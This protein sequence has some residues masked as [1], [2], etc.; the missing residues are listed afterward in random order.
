MAAIEHTIHLMLEPVS[1][2]TAVGQR[3][4]VARQQQRRTHDRFAEFRQQQARHFVVGHADADGAPLVVLQAPRRFL[5]G[6]QQEGVR[7]RRRRLEHAE[8]PGF[9]LGV[10]GDLGE[11]AAH[12]REMV[13]AIGLADAPDAIE[14]VLVADVAAERVAG[15]R[16]VHD[17]RRRRAR[18]RRRAGSGAAADCRDEARNTGS[19]VGTLR[20]Q[21]TAPRGAVIIRARV[22]PR[23]RRL[24]VTMQTLLEYAPWI[25]FGL[26]YKFG[27]GI[28]PGDRRAHGR[29]DAAAR[30]IT[31]SAHAR[32]RR[33]TSVLTVLVWVF[34]AATLILHDVRFLQWKASVIYWLDRH[35][36]SPA[37]SG[38]A[39]RPCSNACMGSGLPEGATV[40]ASHVAQDARCSRA[41]FYL[42]LGGVEHLDRLTRSEADWVTFKIWIAIPLAWSSSSA[43]CSTCCVAPVHPRNGSVS[44][45][46]RSPA[47]RARS[48][49]A[50]RRCSRSATTAPNTP[51]TPARAKAAISTSSSP[52]PAFAGVPALRKAPD[53]LCC[54]R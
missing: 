13:M 25:V 47:R 51:A 49:P 3:Q 23:R 9:H 11:V 36:W 7:P 44:T 2:L 21:D 42:L 39:R 22:K 27:G 41:L 24:G 12:Q 40:P 15:I 52:P 30:R 45:A 18:F 54:R 16:R 43:W 53:G 50:S 1:D 17:E 5:R 35:R 14:R 33:C 48:R 19:R 6:R 32:C 46:R 34:G 38:S 37:A 8:L 4:L 31:G 28:Y 29:D 10:L 20:A 26:V